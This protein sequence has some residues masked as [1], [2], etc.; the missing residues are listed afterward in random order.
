MCAVCRL[1]IGVDGLFYLPLFSADGQMRMRCG[2]WSGRQGPL[3]SASP[4]PSLLYSFR[5]H[6]SKPFFL[7]CLCLCLCTVALAS[8]SPTYI[9]T[10]T[11]RVY[12]PLSLYL[13][14]EGTVAASLS[15]LSPSFLKLRSSLTQSITNHPFP[16]SLEGC[17]TMR[18]VT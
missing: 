3:I 9:R 11:F 13:G 16:L 4:V 12:E 5:T 18:R 2:G 8:S 6:P 14:R 15:L 17:L 7:R 1:M 10:H